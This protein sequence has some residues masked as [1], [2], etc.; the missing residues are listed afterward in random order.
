MPDWASGKGADAAVVGTT[1]CRGHQVR[2]KD[3]SAG[4]PQPGRPGASERDAKRPLGVA[5]PGRTGTLESDD[6]CA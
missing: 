5:L 4:H 1:E 2:L 3:V 6:A